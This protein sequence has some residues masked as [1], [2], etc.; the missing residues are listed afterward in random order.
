MCAEFQP[1]WNTHWCF[2]VEF[3]KCKEK[4]EEIKTKFWLLVSQK[5]LERFSSNLACRLLVLGSTSVANLVYYSWIRDHRA[6]YRTY[7]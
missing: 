7:V 2:M 1:D 3:T 5:C 6:T 4:N